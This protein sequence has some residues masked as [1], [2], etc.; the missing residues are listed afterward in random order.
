MG[1]GHSHGMPEFSCFNVISNGRLEYLHTKGHFESPEHFY[2]LY[3]NIKCEIKI[4]S[5]AEKKVVLRYTVHDLKETDR[6]L[7]N[8]P[9]PIS[10]YQWIQ[11]GEK[12]LD[13]EQ[14]QYFSQKLPSGTFISSEKCSFSLDHDC[15]FRYPVF[16]FD[17]YMQKQTPNRK[18]AFLILTVE[19]DYL[20]SNAILYIFL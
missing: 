14:M 17:T 4:L 10:F 5:M 18:N 3:H 2:L 1:G 16:A 13:I 11:C 9:I 8:I 19:L 15:I 6:V 7:V 12:R 20:D